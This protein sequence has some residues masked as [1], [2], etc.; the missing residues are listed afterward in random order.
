[1]PNYVKNK[2]TLPKEVAEKY[3]TDNEFDFNKVVPQP[4][5]IEQYTFGTPLID[6][7]IIEKLSD[8]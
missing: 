2:L 5:E 4:K 8:E 1:M 7:E 3:I 6:K